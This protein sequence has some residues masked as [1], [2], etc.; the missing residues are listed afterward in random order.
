MAERGHGSIVL[1][2]SS[3][4]RQPAPVGAARGA[5]QAG[6]EILTRYWATEFGPAGVRANTVSPGP[7]I[8]EGT[9]AMTGERIGAMDSANARGRAGTPQEIGDR[10]LPGGPGRQLRQWCCPVRRR[11]RT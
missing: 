4:A 8:T 7:V 9:K 2:G 1:V 3:A 5:S 6:A 10:L 11:S